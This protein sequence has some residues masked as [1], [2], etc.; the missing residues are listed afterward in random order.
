[1]IF[2]QHGI[3]YRCSQVHVYIY[4]YIGIDPIFYQGFSNIFPHR[5][6]WILPVDHQVPISIA[7]N[8]LDGNRSI[9]DGLI[10]YRYGRLKALEIICTPA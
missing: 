3:Q 1:M 5:S 2:M 10:R 9:L 6:I 7:D 4:N 8:L